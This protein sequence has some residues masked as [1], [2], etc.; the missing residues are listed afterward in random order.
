MRTSSSRPTPR[1]PDRVMGSFRVSVA[2]AL[3]LT[4]LVSLLRAPERLAHPQFWAEDAAVFFIEAEVDGA[5]SIASPYA[6][7]V[8]LYPRLVAYV[9]RFVPVA[10]VPALY[11]VASFCMFVLAVLAALRATRDRPPWVGA[12]C[13][14][15]LLTVPFVD[16]VWFVLT[17]TQWIGAAALIAIIGAPPPASRASGIAVMTLLVLV[18]LTGPFALILLPCALLCAWR[19]QDRRD[20]MLLAVLAVA[21]LLCILTLAASARTSPELSM[22]ARL[23]TS[24]FGRPKLFLAACLAA[25][26]LAWGAWVGYRRDDRLLLACGTSGLLLLG[27]VAVAG[28]I[29]MVGGLPHV[30]GRYAFVPWVA[31]V[32]TL[33]LL[34]ARGG[35]L[36]RIGLAATAALCA[37]NLSLQPL[38]RH[39]WP[40]VARCLE[41]HAAC[42]ATVNPGWELLLPG[43]G[44]GDA[45]VRPQ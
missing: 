44:T 42:P 3:A 14:L 28:P 30:G 12:A 15:A 37:L 38:A 27:A 18:A 13:G 11:V 17:N 8:L 40:A 19:S 6:G 24:A 31:T 32:W 41:Q 39:D 20:G 1:S 4:A 35:R 23:A 7:Y 26:T 25:T 16:E 2:V 21:A 33:I 5:A 9:G 36:P 22:A 34:A 45:P 29:A 10:Q 43:R